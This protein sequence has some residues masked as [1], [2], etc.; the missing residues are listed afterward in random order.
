MTVP[1]TPT[2]PSKR[3]SNVITLNTAGSNLLLF[4]CPSTSALLSWAASLRLAAWEKSRLE[5]IYTAHLIRITLTGEVI[6]DIDISGA[7]LTSTIARDVPTTLIH[8]KTEGWARVR[9]AGQTDW[10]R[11]WFVVQEGNELP[12]MGTADH[13]SASTMKKKRMSN[14]FSSKDHTTGQAGPA[15]PLVSMYLSPKAKDR[16]KPLLTVHDVTQAFGVYPERPELINRSTL[17]KIEGKFGDYELAGTL[18]QLEGWL[19]AM[20][21]LETNATGQAAEMLKWIVGES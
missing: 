11:V 3:Y 5:E 14:L 18:R 19:L 6:S 9:I 12:E 7:A 15:K 20:P 16:K 2:A 17:I 1:A 13:A 10:K 8:G 4:S 21:E